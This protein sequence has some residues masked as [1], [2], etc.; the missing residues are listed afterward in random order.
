MKIVFLTGMSGTGKTA[1]AKELCKNDKYNYINSFT[2]RPKRESYEFGH[3]FVDTDFMD[4]ILDTEIVVAYSKIDKYR[5]CS[6]KYQFD[7]NKI[8]V[9]V[10]D[11]NGINDTLNFFPQADIMSILIRRNKVDADCVRINRDVCVPHRG[12]VDFLINN[13]SS[14]ESAVGVV[15][16]LVSFDLF[17]KPSHTVQTIQEKIDYL[18][19]QFRYLEKIK[20]SYLED[21]WY[22][23]ERQYNALCQ[24]VSDKINKEFEDV[25][26]VIRP[27]KKP[28]IYDG[29]LNFNVIGEYKD[30]IEWTIMDNLVSRMSYHAHQFCKERGYN[31]LAYHLSISEE[32]IGDDYL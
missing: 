3:E 18:D 17:N 23:Y 13:N 31:E 29:F 19:E 32:Y 14:I 1:I 15:N 22:Y 11:V 10:A 20:E 2:D 7:E 4:V 12:D 26:I 9:Y 27:D 8:N 25:E 6:L 5:Y 24:Y 16:T 21:L 28:E 30:D